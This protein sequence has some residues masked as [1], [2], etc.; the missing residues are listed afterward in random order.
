MAISTGGS[1]PA[2]F[3]V[4]ALVVL[5]ASGLVGPRA[6]AAATY[7]WYL[8]E[9]YTAPGYHEYICLGNSGTSPATA[10]LTFLFNGS[11]SQQMNCTIP[12]QSR[13][14]IDVNAA[15]GPGREVSA[16]ISSTRSDIAIERSQYFD[17]QGTYMGNHV[18]GAAPAASNAW[19][20]AEGYTGR[21]F[22]EYVCVLNP[23]GYSASLTFR[24]QT[25]A[26]E[27]VRSGTVVA[28]SRSTFKVNDVLGADVESSLK[29][30]S[31]RPVVAE[32][33][34]YFDYLG[35]GSYHWAGGHCVMGATAPGKSYYF[36]EGTT[37]PGFEEWITLQ[38]ANGSPISVTATYQFA[39]GQ[40]DPLTRTYPVGPRSR[41]TIEVGREVGGGRDVS[42]RLS[43]RSNFLAERPLYY[44]F[45][46]GGCD[47]EGGNCTIGAPSASGRWF[48][49]EGYTGQY[50]E[51][52][53]CVQNTSSQAS[54]VTVQYFTQESGALASKSVTVGANSRATILVNEHAGPNL[55]LASLILVTSGPS[56]VVERPIYVDARGNP[57]HCYVPPEP[58]PDPDP[59]P[60]PTPTGPVVMH[61]MCF[62]PYLTS[63]SVTVEQ[64]SA[65]L[66]K[67]APYTEWI[68]GFCS[69]DEWD[70]M[71]ELAHAKGMKI[72][73][74]ADIWSDLERN[75]R[76]VDQL[77][78]QV[79]RGVV[80]LALVGD[81]MLENH[82]LSEAQLIAYIQQV[83][84]A[85]A[86]VSTSQTAYYWRETPGVIAACDFIT[87]NIYPYWE[88]VSIDQAIATLDAGYREVVSV[89]GGKKVIVETGWPT[90]GQ[91][92]GAAAPGEANAARYLSEFMD[93]AE[94]NNVEYFYFEAFDESWKDEGGCGPHWGLWDTNAVLKPA[95]SAVLN[96]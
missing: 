67:I 1:L 43:S 83:K 92:N 54:S 31:S 17:Y 48:L 74:G 84:A 27:L 32:R 59:D 33:P 86:Q 38:N 82:A 55:S 70:A 66:D 63:W 89:A 93:W 47:F 23:G 3:A 13:C 25:P 12:A 90:A 75:Q 26:G 29:L 46:H 5:L 35:T 8:A 72:A 11:A 45:G 51:E 4:L 79:R 18:V 94:A 30:E 52:W 7:N 28:G 22:D 76:E 68:R 78:A 36:A 64:V 71:P 60:T 57:C 39:P 62:S 49:A 85:G 15:V 88:G 77:V 6:D 20:F 87:A 19:Y 50:F 91:L 10:T 24:F 40:G 53:L 58:P 56:V 96:P 14:T 9:G 2:A 21:G 69:E 61:G 80:D 65:L 37:R 41:H 42:V 73:A 95:Y 16:K 34:I 81:E 44:C